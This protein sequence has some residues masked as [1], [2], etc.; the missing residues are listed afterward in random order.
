VLGFFL[1]YGS[2]KPAN[3]PKL[4]EKTVHVY[5]QC[6]T[7][8]MARPIWTNEG[9]ERVIRHN[10]SERCSPKLWESNPNNSNFGFMDRT[11]TRKRQKDQIVITSALFSQS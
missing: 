10:G 1:Q 5:T 7:M 11:F 3:L 4:R 2:W 6:Y 9:L 8:H